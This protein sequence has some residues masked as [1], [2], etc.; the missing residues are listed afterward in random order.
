MDI[1]L[2]I[3]WY[4]VLIFSMTV[5]EAAHAWAAL[6]LGDPTAYV[7]GQVTLDPVPHIRREPFGMVLVPILT[8][9]LWGNWMMGWASAPYDPLWAQEHPRRAAWMALAGPLSNLL[10]VL[11]AVVLIHVGFASQLFAFPNAF[12]FQQVVAGTDDGMA[13]AMAVFVSLLF[14]LNLLLFVLNLIPV[15]PLDGSAA[16]G[17]FLSDENAHRVQEWMSQPTF[18]MFGILIAW[19]MIRRI[20]W[21]VFDTAL[22]LLIGSLA[23][24][25]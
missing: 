5:H 2:G 7:G 9:F 20:F 3:V 25:R 24:A 13:Q 18:S 19:F 8:F 23:W 22:D 15:P 4:F 11:L 14:S 21:P 1:A 10:L 17:V 6:R 12:T 16:V